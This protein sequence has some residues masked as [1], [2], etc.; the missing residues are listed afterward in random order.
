[1][2]EGAESGLHPGL[3]CSGRVEGE[4]RARRS[5]GAQGKVLGVEGDGRRSYCVSKKVPPLE[6]ARGRFF[7]RNGGNKDVS[8]ESAVVE[9]RDGL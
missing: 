1:M 2:P 5:G 8:L 3:L 7:K 9:I 6:E 4:A